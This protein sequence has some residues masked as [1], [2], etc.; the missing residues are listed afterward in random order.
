MGAD[1]KNCRTHLRRILVEELIGRYDRDAKLARLREHR[2]DPASV[3][4][5]VLN[6][7]AVDGEERPFLAG[8]RAHS[9][10]S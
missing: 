10:A 2:V 9:S 6:L 3:R 4:H 7:V 5:E 8:E 1:G